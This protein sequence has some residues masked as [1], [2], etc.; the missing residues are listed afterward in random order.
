MVPNLIWAPD[1]F[2]HQEIWSPRNLVPEKF[3]PTNFGPC[4]NMLYNEFHAGTNFF[5][6]QIS[7]GPKM[8]GAQM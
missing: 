2:G 6:A 7:W 1:F 5:R 4:M 3:G 8:S